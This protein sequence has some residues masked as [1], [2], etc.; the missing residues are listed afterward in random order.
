MHTH[1]AATSRTLTQ[2]VKSGLVQR[3]PDQGDSRRLMVALTDHGREVVATIAA[4]RRAPFR[5]SSAI[6]QELLKQPRRYGALLDRLTGLPASAPACSLT[7]SRAWNG[8]G[9]WP[10][11]RA[12]SAP[13]SC[14]RWPPAARSWRRRYVPCGGGGGLP[15][16][17]HL[18]V[19]LPRHRVEQLIQ[20][21]A[22]KPFA[23]AGRTFREW[24]LIDNRDQTR[25]AELI[26]EARAFAGGRP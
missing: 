23:P 17:P 6:V 8:R 19:K 9:W 4:P 16:R 13:A 2:L 11:S 21:G 20:A 5:R 22:G 18:I 24:V 12:R 14:T 26:D 1:P 15:G 7:G 3:R 10:G 25:W